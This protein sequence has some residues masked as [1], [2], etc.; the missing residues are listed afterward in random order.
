MN[1]AY[2]TTT[3]DGV[4][5]FY[6]EAG[7]AD[8][9]KL[10]L[11]HG[12]P[13]SSHQYR[14]LIPALADR[15]HLVAPDYPGFGNSGVPDPSTFDYTFAHLTEVVEGLLE[16]IGFTGPMGIY[17]EGYGGAIGCRL[18]DRHPDWLRWQVIQNANAYEDGLSD[19]W[20]P[21]RAVWRDRNPETE[22]ALVPYTEEA[23]VKLIYTHG[24]RDVEALSP[25][26]WNMD[27]WFLTRPNARQAQLDLFADFGTN[28]AL[29]PDWQRGWRERRP[30]TLIVWGRNDIFFVPTAGEMYLRDLP[31]AELVQFDSGHFAV[32][33][34]L[35][36]IVE[37]IERFHDKL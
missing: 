20:A 14:N 22:A 32:E 19:A 27:S 34:S 35:D 30:P 10:L 4:P 6:R 1:I 33:D 23:G 36:E 17:Q 37:A 15:F 24:H 13:A 3:V 26:N 16:Q 5:V 12:Y 11:L 31:D 8:A 25:D 29:F 7:P 9:P 21:L 28:V 2:R 18:V